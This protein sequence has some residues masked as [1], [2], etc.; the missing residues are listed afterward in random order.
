MMNAM[1]K[2]RMMAPR[3][4]SSSFSIV[5]MVS[6]SSSLLLFFLTPIIF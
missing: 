2:T 3:P 4:H 1:T 5:V 6:F